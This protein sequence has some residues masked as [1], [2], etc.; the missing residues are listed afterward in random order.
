MTVDLSKLEVGD[1]VKTQDGNLLVVVECSSLD[2]GTHA[3]SFVDKNGSLFQKVLNL[4]HA[5]FDIVSIHKKE[6][7][8][9]QQA[10]EVPA[11]QALAEGKLGWYRTR[12]GGLAEIIAII[13]PR[14]GWGY[15][16]WGFLNHIDKTKDT[17]WTAEG[18]HYMY[19]DR[20]ND[21][22]TYLGTEK[23]KRKVKRTV[24]VVRWVNVGPS[25]GHLYFPTKEKADEWAADYGSDRIACVELRGSYEVEEEVEEG[26]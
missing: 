10:T 20:P 23:P 24:E 22:I 16:V 5:Y 25:T 17:G 21:L 9:E 1:M 15:T 2:D 8:M 7:P 3:L 13:P 6:K 4:N 18:K 19:G 12:E 26:V 14:L 11:A